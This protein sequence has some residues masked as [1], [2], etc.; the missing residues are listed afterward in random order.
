MLPIKRKAIIDGM[1]PSLQS[2]EAIT[3]IDYVETQKLRLFLIQKIAISIQMIAGAKKY[4]SEKVLT[5]AVFIWYIK[6]VRGSD[7]GASE[8]F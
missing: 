3:G 6:N 5:K 8:F 1:F 7:S 2:E 4:F